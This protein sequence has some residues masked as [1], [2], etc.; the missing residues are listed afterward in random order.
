MRGTGESASSMALVVGIG[1]SII[2][3]S[4]LTL[5]QARGFIYMYAMREAV[6]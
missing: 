5:S 6:F 4:M 1:Y 2:K 3:I